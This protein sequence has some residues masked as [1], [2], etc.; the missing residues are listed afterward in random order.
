[1]DLKLCLQYSKTD[2]E[3]DL[4]DI[5]W[6]HFIYIKITFLSKGKFQTGTL[7]SLQN[8][9]FAQKSVKYFSEKGGSFSISFNLIPA[10]TWGKL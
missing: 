5:F 10:H 7:L 1:M 3:L 8:S 9:R 6:E 4:F 2:A